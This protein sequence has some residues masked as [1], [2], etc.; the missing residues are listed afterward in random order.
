MRLS[1]RIIMYSIKNVVPEYTGGGIWIYS[2]MV[3]EGQWFLTSDDYPYVC[4]LD[5]DPFDEQ[6]EEDFTFEEWQVEHQCGEAI[7]DDA[8]EF[9]KQMLSVIQSMNGMT[10]K[11]I[12]TRRDFVEANAEWIRAYRR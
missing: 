6:Y 11:D 2:G 12:D 8:V 7:G 10:Q 1:E 3:A 5:V 4:I 9:W